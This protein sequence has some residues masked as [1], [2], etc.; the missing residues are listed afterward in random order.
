MCS[1]S[2]TPGL[3]YYSSTGHSHARFVLVQISVFKTHSSHLEDLG[4]DPGTSAGGKGQVYEQVAGGTRRGRV[5]RYGL[6]TWRLEQEQEQEE[7]KTLFLKEN[8]AYAAHVK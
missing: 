6:P 5:G 4:A 3:F 7:E 8:E 2:N 1:T